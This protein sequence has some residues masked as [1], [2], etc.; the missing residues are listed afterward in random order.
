[1]LQFDKLKLSKDHKDINEPYVI[2][3][4]KNSYWA[5]D[6]SEESIALS[7]QNSFCYNLLFDG[8]QIGFARVVTDQVVF[9]YLMDVLVDPV[10][11]GKGYGSYFIDQILT[12]PFLAK[13]A[14]IRLATK[15]AHPFYHKKGFR[16]IKHPDFL[17]EKKNK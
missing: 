3:F 7:L 1:M 9:A 11:Q 8:Q 15:D 4:L 5:K 2:N 10:F 12:D 17:M 13:V 16:N 6:R 14:R